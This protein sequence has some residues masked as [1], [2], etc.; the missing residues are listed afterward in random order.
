MTAGRSL[1]IALALLAVAALAT[2]CRAMTPAPETQA[3]IASKPARDG[4]PRSNIWIAYSPGGVRSSSSPRGGGSALVSV[5]GLRPPLFSVRL[6]STKEDGSIEAD[7]ATPGGFDSRHVMAADISDD[8][9]G[10]D[11]AGRREAELER[12]LK[13]Y[14]PILR[15]R[16]GGDGE[17][18]VRRSPALGRHEACAR[19]HLRAAIEAK[20][21]AAENDDRRRFLQ[22]R[23]QKDF[24]APVS[25]PVEH[26][27]LLLRLV[28]LSLPSSAYDQNPDRLAGGPN[29][30]PSQWDWRLREIRTHG[31]PVRLQLD[32]RSAPSS[33]AASLCRSLAYRT[34]SDPRSDTCTIQGVIDRRD[35]WPITIG[36]SR[37]GKAADGATESDYRSFNRVVPLQG[38]VPPS[39]PCAAQ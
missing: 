39:N 34:I 31:R 38:F 32:L 7:L 2:G 24:L 11:D 23:L 36:I 14:R 18:K 17:M 37:K 5:G 10:S 25:A 6:R 9:W 8:G 3:R 33:P 27:S 1:G 26:A 16:I 20:A 13:H 35:G 15:L 22:K 30:R 21:T 12:A 28:M 4:T 19:R 29:D